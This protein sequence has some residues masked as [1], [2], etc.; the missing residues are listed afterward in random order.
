ML[1]KDQFLNQFIS[2]SIHLSKKDYS[3]LYN[4]SL[5]SKNKQFITQNQTKLFDKLLV[6]YQKQIKKSGYDIQTLLHLP[7]KIQVLESKL[8]YLQARVFIEKGN[9][10]IK[11]PF[12]TQFITSLKKIELHEYKWDKQN[13]QYVAPLST[14]N[15]KVAVNIVPK[16]FT[17]FVF[18]DEVKELVDSV[19]DYKDVKYWTPTLIKVDKQFYIAACNEQV[20]SATQN[21]VIDDSPKTLFIL[22]QYGIKIDESVSQQDPHLELAANFYNTIDI[23]YLDLLVSLI[24]DLDIETVFT[25]RDIIHNKVISNDVKLAFLEQGINCKP[26]HTENNDKGILLKS[27]S[28]YRG[29]FT[30]V[31]KVITITNSRPIKIR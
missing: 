16:Y 11:S 22:S 14:Y 27:T 8:E 4:I 18:S 12:N 15:L 30:N 2:G 24:K 13:K 7:W 31:E 23:E 5:A 25:A 20:F 26:F 9:V 28:F 6:K 29:P 17:N 10:I 19:K 1:S 21:I 3:F